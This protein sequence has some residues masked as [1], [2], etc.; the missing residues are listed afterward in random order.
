M[1]AE[2][3]K[4]VEEVEEEYRGKSILARQLAASPHKKA[5]AEIQSLYGRG[6]DNRS[7]GE[8]FLSFFSPDSGRMA[9]IFWMSLKGRFLL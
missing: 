2:A 4:R 7:H 6:L 5:M 9:F 8:R 3:E 1:R